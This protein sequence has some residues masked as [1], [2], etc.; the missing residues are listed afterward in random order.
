[1]AT[2]ADLLRAHTDLRAE[3]YDHLHALVADWAL[4]A[5]LSFADLLLLVPVDEAGGE[6]LV[7]AQIRP[8]TGPTAY[9]NDEVGS[10]VMDRWVVSACWKERRIVREGEPEWDRGVPVRV[11]AIPVRHHDRVIAV[12][13]RDTNL[14]TARSPSPLELAYLRSAADLAQM[15]AEGTFP[16]HG[17]TAELTE[18]PRVGDGMLRLDERGRVV[19]ASPNALSAYRRLGYTG[20]VS[21]EELRVVHETLG[22]GTV[23]RPVWRAAQ[24]RRPVAVE[25]TVEG[26]AVLLRAIPLLPG[27]EQ[28]VLVLVRDVSELRRREA[29]LLTKDATIR[30]IH[31]RVKNN[32]QTVASLPRLQA[33]RTNNPEGREALIEA[34]RRVSSIA[35]V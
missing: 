8:A 9:H 18:A 1:M 15:V 28:G 27:R 12:L 10:V 32:L 2:L 13:A 34:V 21:G 33:R 29:Q 17:T 4:L 30:E 11:E 6:F 14:A 24:R 26:T 22:L 25:L 19:F 16:F 20:N 3:D 31:H 23:G 5:D 35:L 7:V